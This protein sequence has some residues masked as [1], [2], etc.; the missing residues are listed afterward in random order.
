MK[1]NLR[2][3]K[4]FAQECT[5]IHIL[6]HNISN[7]QCCKFKDYNTNKS[8]LSLI[9]KKIIKIKKENYKNKTKDMN[10]GVLKLKFGV[11]EKFI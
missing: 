11:L 1:F 6:V 9:D 5:L 10:H 3:I 7:E 4:A 2:L 8:Y